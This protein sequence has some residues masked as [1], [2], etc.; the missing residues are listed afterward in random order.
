MALAERASEGHLVPESDQA[1]SS[2]SLTA[3]TKDDQ[4][5]TVNVSAGPDGFLLSRT[6]T[7]LEKLSETSTHWPPSELL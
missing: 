1:L 2:P 3:D 4:P 6:G 7:T 5:P